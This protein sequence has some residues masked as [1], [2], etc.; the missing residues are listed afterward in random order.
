MP[1]DPEEC[2]LRLQLLDGLI[3]RNEA[4]LQTSLT[5]NSFDL[6]TSIENM[7]QERT[8]LL[9]HIWWMRSRPVR[10]ES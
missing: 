2:A 7:Q 3:A 10:I 1:T 5:L 4:A 6:E 9:R 8:D